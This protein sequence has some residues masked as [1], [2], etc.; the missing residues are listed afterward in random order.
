MGAW[1]TPHW[2]QVS[3]K[4]LLFVHGISRFHL[5]MSSKQE[6]ICE[7]RAE[8][9]RSIRPGWVPQALALWKPK[10]SKPT[11]HHLQKEAFVTRRPRFSVMDR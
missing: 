1:A 9:A 4:L 10:E 7:K 8:S 11:L 3:D 5:Q 6:E 2:K